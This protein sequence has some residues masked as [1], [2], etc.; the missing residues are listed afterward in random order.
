MYIV[1]LSFIIPAIELTVCVG[2]SPFSRSPYFSILSALHFTISVREWNFFFLSGLITRVTDVL[3]S[4]WKS[5]SYHRPWK[6]SKKSSTELA[7]WALHM[8]FCGIYS[9]HLLTNFRSRQYLVITQ[10]HQYL[11]F[12]K[13]LIQESIPNQDRT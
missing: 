12:A 7:V 1:D 5:S 3:I 9:R 13:A 10:I 8:S 11:L 2:G 6:V 4:M